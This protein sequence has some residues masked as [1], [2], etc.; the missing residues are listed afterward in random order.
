MQTVNCRLYINVAQ[1]NNYIENTDV[2]AVEKHSQVQ[3]QKETYVAIHNLTS[4]TNQKR[5]QHT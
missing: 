1:V 3:G 4:L 5:E 2:L